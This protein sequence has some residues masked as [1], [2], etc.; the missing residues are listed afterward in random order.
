MSTHLF[1]FKRPLLIALDIFDEK[2]PPFCSHIIVETW[3]DGEDTEH[4]RVFYNY[5]KVLEMTLG[6]F[7]RFT[8]S[9]VPGDYAVECDIP[10]RHKSDSAALVTDTLAKKD[11]TSF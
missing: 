3:L 1:F 6:D 2:W 8:K 4:L 5:R 7:A 9:K 10:F 11:G